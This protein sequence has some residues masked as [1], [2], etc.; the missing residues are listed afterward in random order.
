[1]REFALRTDSLSV[2]GQDEYPEKEVRVRRSVLA[3][4]NTPLARDLCR[5]YGAAVQ[6]A[7][8]EATV[9]RYSLLVG[10]DLL[11]CF[12]RHL[13]LDHGIYET[14]IERIHHRLAEH[15]P[16]KVDTL[17]ALPEL[18]LRPTP[19]RMQVLRVIALAGAAWEQW[20][21]EARRQ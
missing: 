3:H 12:R 15:Y 21:R 19:N 8:D 13:I 7:A 2:H 5:E 4:Q 18:Y 14:S 11:K 10:K 17:D 20:T 6:R 1:M 16:K 9:L